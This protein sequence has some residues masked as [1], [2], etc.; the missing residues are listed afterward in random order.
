MDRAAHKLGST[1]APPPPAGAGQG[2]PSTC[3][4]APVAE[5]PA[6]GPE[7]LATLEALGTKLGLDVLGKLGLLPKKPDPVDF[8]KLCNAAGNARACAANS[9]KRADDELARC[10]AAL[11]AAQAAAEAADTALVQAEA[12]AQQAQQNLEQD[13]AR[14]KQKAMQAGAATK[15]PAA[16]AEDPNSNQPMAV[17]AEDEEELQ[18]HIKAAQEKLERVRADKRQRKEAEEAEGHAKQ[19]R[20]DLDTAARTAIA[21]KKG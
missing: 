12:A 21:T 15:G 19:A 5:P 7:E 9:K 17:D 18:K 10:Q 3:E 11:L 16:A 14:E 13:R 20:C 2:K 6:L 8:L 4:G 1:V